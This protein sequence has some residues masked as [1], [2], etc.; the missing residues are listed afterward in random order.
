MP[1]S[2]THSIVGA[3]IGYSLVLHGVEGI[4]WWKLGAIGRLKLS[5]EACHY[6]RVLSDASEIST[7]CFLIVLSWFISPL[8]AGF[9]SVMIFLGVNRFILTKKDPIKPGL[10]SLPFFYGLTIFVNL[11][12]VFVNGPECNARNSVYVYL[13]YLHI[14]GTALNHS[15]ISR[16]NCFASTDF[17]IRSKNLPKWTQPIFGILIAVTLG[18]IVGTFVRIWAVPRIR[19][20]IAGKMNVLKLLLI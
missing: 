9:V 15:T 3:V 13:H 4:V 6:V 2:G 18:L 17:R 12:S 10:C 20:N 5:A 14:A 11:I 16:L 7:L 8:M 1:I 19:K